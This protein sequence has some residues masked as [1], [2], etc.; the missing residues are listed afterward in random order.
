[1]LRKGLVVLA[2]LAMAACS[3]PTTTTPSASSVEA[4]AGSIG[5]EE[6][7]RGDFGEDWPLTVDSGV[8]ACQGAGAVTF[9][10]LDGTTYAVNGLA[11]SA[12]PY[13]EIDPIWADS[14]KPK[15]D[16]GPLIDRGL[17]L[18]ATGD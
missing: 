14:G 18:C 10:A 7:S 13:P 4:P 16:I 6:V 15:V 8:L 11:Q 12:T 1:M 9:T 5:A 2:A 3:N 17:D